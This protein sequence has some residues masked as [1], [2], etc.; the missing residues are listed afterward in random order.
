MGTSRTVQA[1]LVR[2]LR[3]AFPPCDAECALHRGALAERPVP[4]E[5]H[6]AALE[7]LAA[8][9]YPHLS[10]G[11]ALRAIGAVSFEAQLRGPAG[12]LI[13]GMSELGPERAVARGTGI[14]SRYLSFGH[15]ETRS[16]NRFCLRV[17]CE[18]SPIPGEYY[19]GLITPLLEL[20]GTPLV[21]FDVESRL[22][23]FTLDL[24]Y[25]ARS[26][27]RHPRGKA[28]RGALHHP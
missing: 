22:D 15:W 16:P 14:A 23:G 9:H 28:S 26:S 6:L 24:F 27:P 5:R 3:G 17:T 20:C 1:A 11:A 21:I 25:A 8:V 2:A 4:L 13:R 19:V 10:R 18:E 7:H 12:P